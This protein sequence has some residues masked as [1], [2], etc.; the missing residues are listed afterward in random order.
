[1][2]G[3][4]VSDVAV[5]RIPTHCPVTARSSI[6]DV[7]TLDGATESVETEERVC[8][9]IKHFAFIQAYAVVVI[10]RGEELQSKLET[11]SSLSVVSSLKRVVHFPKT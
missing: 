8:K 1:M 4:R 6:L 11:W 2:T 9:V 7:A 5:F 3:P 10:P